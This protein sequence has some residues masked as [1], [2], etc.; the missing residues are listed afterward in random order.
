MNVV[1]TGGH[2]GLGL[3]LTRRLIAENAQV[4]LI[5]RSSSRMA[6][7]PEA[8][9]SAPNLT[10]FEADLTSREAIDAVAQQISDAWPHV[11][12]LFNNAGVLLGEFRQSSNGNEMHLEV[13]TLAPM[14][15][16]HRLK[17]RLDEAAHPMVINTVTGSMHSTVFDLSEVTDASKFR[18]L[19]GAYLH[20]KAALIQ[21]MNEL[22]Q[23]PEWQNVAIRHVNPGANKTSMTAGEGMPFWLRPFR[24]LLFSAPTKG[25]NLLYDAAFSD[26][27]QGKTGIWLDEAKERAVPATLSD[28][29]RAALLERLG[30]L[31]VT[32]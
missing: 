23:R 15:L 6:D 8:V 18:R 1:M 25:A 21:L 30:P 24:W 9:R 4:G 7:V 10:V 19:F 16:T 11:D 29:D 2:T 13:N 32:G 12:V 31:S 26:R 5:V 22:A 17:P 14:R 20:S 3:E 27:Y 28:D